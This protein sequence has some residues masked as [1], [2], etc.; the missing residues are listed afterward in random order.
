M[1][2]G[3]VGQNMTSRYQLESGRMLQ[4]LTPAIVP[5]LLHMPRRALSAGGASDND[6][7]AAE[8]QARQAM[9]ADERQQR[10]EMEAEERQARLAAEAELK[11]ARIVAQAEEK[12]AR[13]AAEADRKRARIE[14]NSERERARMM[15]DVE[16]QRTKRGSAM[17]AVLMMLGTCLLAAALLF[18]LSKGN[19]ETAGN[20]I[21][22]NPEILGGL[23][24]YLGVLF[25]V[26]T[27][28]VLGWGWFLALVFVL[29]ALAPKN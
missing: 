4:L 8:R 9:E 24:C 3:L 5:P 15:S 22:K 11:R 28:R 18:V 29:V 27:I 2:K 23:L 26:A 21:S 12:Q 25:L 6:Y 19:L 7:R 1:P 20:I 16:N 17:A 10:R 13:I 14:A